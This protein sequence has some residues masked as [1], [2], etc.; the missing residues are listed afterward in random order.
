V[1]LA[2]I[3]SPHPAEALALVQGS[4]RV[5]YGQLR[6]DV[7]R[8]RAGLAARGVGPD[9]RVGLLCTSSP[10]FVVAYLAILGLGGVAV[11]INP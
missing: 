9:D 4:R 5:N 6:A 11:P 10:E 8:A 2:S 7:E 3:V 1:N